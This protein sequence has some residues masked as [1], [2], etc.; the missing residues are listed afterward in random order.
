M[1]DLLG[2]FKYGGFWPLTS[3]TPE[4]LE[5][6]PITAQSYIEHC[7][8]WAILM[9]HRAG[10]TELP[11][12]AASADRLAASLP[13]DS[14]GCIAAALLSRTFYARAFLFAANSHA[15]DGPDV[16]KGYYDEAKNNERV[17][18]WR[19]DQSKALHAAVMAFADM[20]HFYDTLMSDVGPQAEGG[21]LKPAQAN[22]RSKAG[23]AAAGAKSAV[24][25]RKSQEVWERRWKPHV[26]EL[27]KDGRASDPAIPQDKLA[28][29]IQQQ[30]NAKKGGGIPTTKNVIKQISA[31]EKSGALQRRAPK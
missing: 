25:R 22:M 19:K 29:L 12:D 5:R 1:T 17:Q 10:L 30:W 9:L 18:A 8:Q 21:I 31:Y 3:A 14:I 27:A 13:Q 2:L 11:R 23:A 26:L 16:R 6:P 28:A 7:S 24:T 15:D 20:A 4:E